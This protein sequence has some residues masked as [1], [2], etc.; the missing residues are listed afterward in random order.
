MQTCT[1]Q[2]DMTTPSLTAILV[3]LHENLGWSEYPPS[4][5]MRAS[6]GWIVWPGA[7]SDWPERVLKL[8]AFGQPLAPLFIDAVRNGA[9]FIERG[10]KLRITKG[11]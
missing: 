10:D 2:T 6:S 3:A 8:A 5:F 1:E 11:R 9:D 4:L 7:P